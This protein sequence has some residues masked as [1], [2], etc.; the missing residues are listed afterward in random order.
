MKNRKLKEFFD[1]TG[2]ISVDDLMD[3]MTEEW[4]NF[5]GG[6]FGESSHYE[7]EARDEDR[8]LEISAILEF[9]TSWSTGYS[10]TNTKVEKEYNKEI[11]RLY[12]EYGEDEEAFDEALYSYDPILLILTVDLKEKLMYADV[13]LGNG[14]SST[15]VARERLPDDEDDFRKA[16]IRMIKAF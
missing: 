7:D 10:F 8:Y 3:I 6:L 9:P 5:R 13:D 14:L 15:E 1:Y 11:D 2:G 4:Q 12:A 16:V